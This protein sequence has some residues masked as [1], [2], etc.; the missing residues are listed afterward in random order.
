[1][2]N[3]SA[4]ALLCAALTSFGILLLW[5]GTKRYAA[6]GDDWASVTP[7]VAGFVLTFVA[8][9]FLIQALFHMRGLNKLLSGHRQVAAWHVGAADWDRFRTFDAV[10]AGSNLSLLVN[11]LW[12]RKKTPAEGVDVIVGET[13]LVVDGSYHVLRLGGI[14]ELRAIGWIDNRRDLAGSPDCLEFL[15]VY[16]RG[17]GGG[18]RTTLRIPVPH[19]ARPEALTVYRHFSSRIERRHA[20]GAIALRD[21]RRTYR[22]MAFLFGICLL[23][24]GAGWLWADASDWDAQ[25]SLGPLL[26]LIVGLI[27]A[28][29]AAVLAGMT[30]L[31]SPRR[32]C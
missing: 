18:G 29:F 8:A 32:G 23:A 5:L 20:K 15:L 2:R 21:P 26:L 11:D 10:R 31:L 30:F 13:S 25:T 24:F 3:P 12:I 17:E 28:V 14:P 27:G 7:Q 4:K 9:L 19:K 6:V 22:V 16:P 1:M